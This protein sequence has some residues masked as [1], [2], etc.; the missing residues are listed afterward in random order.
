[1]LLKG[2]KLSIVHISGK[3][4]FQKKGCPILMKQPFS[5]ISDYRL[6][7]NNP[8]YGVMSALEVDVHEIEST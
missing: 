8:F 2:F 7:N 6:F 3:N 4:V 1:M 5:G